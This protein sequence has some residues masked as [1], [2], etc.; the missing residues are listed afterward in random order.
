[1]LSESEYLVHKDFP[2]EIQEVFNTSEHIDSIFAASTLNK[3]I[4]LALDIIIDSVE[5]V[6]SNLKNILLIVMICVV[7][8][9]P[10]CN[11]KIFH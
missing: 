1:M 10:I 3:Q 9:W 5:T 6:D 8:L 7:L 4:S 2:S 11:W